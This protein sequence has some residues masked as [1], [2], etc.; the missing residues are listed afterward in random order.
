MIFMLNQKKFFKGNFAYINDLLNAE[1]D[2]DM[3]QALFFGN[4]TEFYDDDEKLKAAKEKSTCQYFLSTVRKN[5][6]KKIQEGGKIP[7]ESVQAM[8][9]NP[10]TFKIEK[11]EFNEAE[12]KRKFTADYKNF[13]R[14]DRFLVPFQLFYNIQAEKNISADIRYQNI[15][16]N[17]EQ[18]F[19]FTIPSNY[20]PI[21]IK[22]K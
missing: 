22:K 15:T 11:L 3:L 18:N 10:H 17:E 4:S 13:K 6:L 19:P 1:L 5:K 20:E 16:I 14:V 7:N 9:I 12:T 21:E 8:W 2:F